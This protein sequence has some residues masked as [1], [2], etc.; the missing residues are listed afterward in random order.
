MGLLKK[1]HWIT[2]TEIRWA[3][4]G[5]E[6]DTP[7]WHSLNMFCTTMYG[8]YRHGYERLKRT[9][10]VPPLS[11]E[12]RETV[13]AT[14]TRADA[15]IKK[16]KIGDQR[17]H[18][19]GFLVRDPQDPGTI[20]LEIEGVRVDSL[21]PEWLPNFGVISLNRTRSCVPYVAVEKPI[22]RS[23]VTRNLTS[24]STAMAIYMGA[25][26]GRRPRLNVPDP[27]APLR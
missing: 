2:P 10:L 23:S 3:L 5:R 7:H 16:L 13:H 11:P 9:N 20:W 6:P 24:T 27:S 15:A 1:K 22:Y 4:E 17:R 8:S 19:L 21:F 14:L 25:V 12:D 18:V 26:L